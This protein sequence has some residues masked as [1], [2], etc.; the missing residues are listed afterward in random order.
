MTEY[1][2]SASEVIRKR[3]YPYNEHPALWDGAGI[4]LE[5]QIRISI[6]SWPQ[7]SQFMAR[8]GPVCECRQLV[9]AETEDDENWEI[10]DSAAGLSRFLMLSR[11]LSIG[12]DQW[13]R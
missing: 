9:R 8:N 6:G 2:L 4:R 7:A 1:Q 11:R 12:L 10:R 3:R 5:R 13:A